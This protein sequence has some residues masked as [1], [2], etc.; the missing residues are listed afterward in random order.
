MKTSIAAQPPSVRLRE[1]FSLSWER[2]GSKQMLLL[3]ACL[4]IFTDSIMQVLI[5]IM[6]EWYFNYLGDSDLPQIRTLLAAFTLIVIAAS[7]FNT[8]GYYI[9]QNL[10][11]SVHRDLAVDLADEAQRLPLHTAQSSHTADIAQRVNRDSDFPWLLGTILDWMGNQA[12]L[13]LLASAYMLQL[14]WRI[15]ICV[16]ILLPLGAL[17]SHLMKRRL[18]RIGSE[19]AN[20]EAIVGQC[21]QDALQGMET[22]RAFGAEHW[23]LG[24]FVTER[25]KLN[26]IYIKRM[27]WQQCVNGLTSSLA[28]LI[29]WGTIL[30]V[31]W[32]AIRGKMSLGSLMAFSV[33]IWRIQGPLIQLGNAWGEVQIRLGTTYRAI[34]LL[35]APKEPALA[36]DAGVSAIADKKP[37]IRL[38]DVSFRYREN[39]GLMDAGHS[40]PTGAEH[41][42]VGPEAA[43]LLT[44][45]SLDIQP[46]S[47]TAIVGPSGGGKS[48]VAK[49]AA[50]LLFPDEG[51]VRIGGTSTLANAEYA[52][53]IVSYVPQ[54]SYLF[55]GTIR[56]NLLKVKSDA[57]EEELIAAAAAA[58][59]HEFIRSLPEGYDTSLKEHGSTL[60]G[61]QRQRL[62]IARAILAD[63]TI[64]ILDEATSALDMDT[65]RRVME[66]I[67][68]RTREQG[69]TLLVIAHR[70]TTVQDADSILVMREGKVVQQGT[71][72]QLATIRDGL[73]SELWVQMNGTTG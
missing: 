4:M 40:D 21:Q 26:K 43:T 68:S 52:R 16:M 50:G 69:R 65:E 11:S 46:G 31:A 56:E 47:F 7:V 23:M 20:Q 37:T 70:L 36:V 41:E 71:H 72:R 64:L 51:D 44:R 48:T 53:S 18:A 58:Q 42:P 24:R 60:S 19:T 2:L 8:I 9:K 14:N 59:A 22:L 62:A 29:N 3:F 15:G 35:R 25:S 66:A 45:V 10:L 1:V 32:L 55:S 34:T 5:P 73:Y 57:S 12:L 27:W 6:M 28:L 30:T 38:H 33:L 63:R 61:G 39:A 13:L 54:T 49:L 67:L 17:G